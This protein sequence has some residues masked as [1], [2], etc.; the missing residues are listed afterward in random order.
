VPSGRS[1]GS[2]RINRPWDTL[3]VSPVMTEESSPIP[4]LEEGAT[5]T[6]PEGSVVPGGC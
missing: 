6:E 1:V 4:P 2:S 5:S 3:A